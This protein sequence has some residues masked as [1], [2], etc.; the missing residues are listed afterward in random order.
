[1]YIVERNDFFATAVVNFAN[2]TK[3]IVAACYC[4]ALLLLLEM[5]SKMLCKNAT[6]I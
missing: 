3:P 6:K 1:M 4:F 2:F 5:W